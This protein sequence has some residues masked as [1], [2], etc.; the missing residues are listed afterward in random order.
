MRFTSGLHQAVCL[1]VLVSIVWTSC[2]LAHQATLASARRHHAVAP[3]ARATVI[4][5]DVVS[6]SS[7]AVTKPPPT[8]PPTIVHVTH[9]G[10]GTERAA[11]DLVSLFPQLDHVLTDCSNATSVVEAVAGAATPRTTL[12]LHSCIVNGTSWDA[13]SLVTAAQK[14][15][16]RVLMTMHD[17]QWVS[18]HKPNPTQR[19]LQ[20]RV[21]SSHALHTAARLMTACDTVIFPT[22][23]VHANYARV[24]G[25]RTMLSIPSAIVPNPDFPIHYQ[26]EAWPP[27]INGVCTVAFV[28]DFLEVKGARTFVSLMREAGKLTGGRGPCSGL[29][30]KVFGYVDPAHDFGLDDAL[31]DDAPL[32][33]AGRESQ[34]ATDGLVKDLHD[35]R[36]HVV[37]LLSTVPETYSYT[38]T[39]CVNSGLPIVYTGHG[40]FVERLQ[41]R[42]RRF[43]QVTKSVDVVQ[44]LKNALLLAKSTCTTKKIWCSD[45]LQLLPYYRTLY[46]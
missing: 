30:F 6:S 3:Q 14:A 9:R 46:P 22:R 37:L 36:V 13:T 45:E 18:P 23:S 21:L 39:H 41:G 4:V 43:F 2:R 40:A 15:G 42:G 33:W 27:I 44:A 29:R 5:S 12:H 24:L 17:Y 31:G 28:G 16:V 25:W 19:E 10:G 11:R 26:T 38:L 32:F 34:T 35:N 8:R 1:L 20:R 7:H